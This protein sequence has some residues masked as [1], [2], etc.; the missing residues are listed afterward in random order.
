MDISSDDDSGDDLGSEYDPNENERSLGLT[1]SLYLAVHLLYYL[2]SVTLDSVSDSAEIDKAH[3]MIQLA[4]G[5]AWAMSWAPD[6]SRSSENDDSSSRNDS[7]IECWSEKCWFAP[8]LLLLFD[9][10]FHKSLVPS[11]HL[12]IPFYFLYT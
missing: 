3:R 9:C 11:F 2:F 12:S 5:S 7:D 8:L 4:Q 10:P 6:D 1:T